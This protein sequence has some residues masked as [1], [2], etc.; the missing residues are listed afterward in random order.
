MWLSLALRAMTAA[1]C[2]SSQPADVNDNSD[3]DTDSNFDIAD[4]SIIDIG[5]EALIRRWDKLKGEGEEN[6]IR[7]EQRG[8]GTN[9]EL[10]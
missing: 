7:E 8:C 5:H 3:V 1:F 9:I 6:W 4:D 10:S 2:V